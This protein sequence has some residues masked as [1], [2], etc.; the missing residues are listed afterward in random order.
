M[1]VELASRAKPV[2][3]PKKVGPKRPSQKKAEQTCRP[4]LEFALE[5]PLEEGR[6][7]ASKQRGQPIRSDWTNS[8]TAPRAGDHPAMSAISAALKPSAPRISALCSPSRG[9]GNLWAPGESE[10]TTG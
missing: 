10:N 5:A 9:G 4:A 3:Q 1:L 7:R 6:F 2:R 8:V